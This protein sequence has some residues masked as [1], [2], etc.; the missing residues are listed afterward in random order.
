MLRW[1]NISLCA[2]LISRTSYY[3]GTK[4]QIGQAGTGFILLGGIK[5]N[6]IGFEA[7]NERLCKIRIKSKYDNLTVI[8]MY[9]PAEDKADTEKEKF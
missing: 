6:I 2:L 7:L 5:N 1:Q 3:S 8:N 9:A 4:N